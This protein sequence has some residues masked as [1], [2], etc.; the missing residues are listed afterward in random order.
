MKKIVLPLNLN[1]VGINVLTAE[2]FQTPKLDEKTTFIVDKDYSLEGASIEIPI[3]CSLHFNG[4]CF[5]NGKIIGNNTHLTSNTNSIFRSGLE[6][7]GSFD[8]AV[9]VSNWFDAQSDTLM[10]KN[11]ITFASNVHN[12]IIGDAANKSYATVMVTCDTGTYTIDDS[13]ILPIG[14]SFDGNGSL[15]K[16]AMA[17]NGVF[18][19]CT[20][21]ISKVNK[22]QLVSTPNNILD[23]FG[24]IGFLNGVTINN[25]TYYS[26]LIYVGDSRLIHDIKVRNPHKVIEWN[27]SYI[28]RKRCYN[29]MCI[30]TNSS[31]V[32]DTSTVE[33]IK[34]TSH[35]I[36]PNVGDAVEIRGISDGIRLFVGSGAQATIDSCINCDIT[37]HN[38]RDVTISH[39]HNETGLIRLIKSSVRVTDSYF[40][41]QPNGNFVLNGENG[42]FSELLLKNIQV[43]KLCD[44]PN[45]HAYSLCGTN[46]NS[47]VVAENVYGILGNGQDAH[48]GPAIM[49]MQGGS[50]INPNRFIL[51]GNEVM[52]DEISLSPLSNTM[53]MPNI[54]ETSTAASASYKIRVLLVV[55]AK[56]NI[57]INHNNI[58]PRT[59]TTN[60]KC[61][62]TFYN[63]SNNS[64]ELLSGLITRV[65]FG[66]ANSGYSFYFDYGMVYKRFDQFSLDYRITSANDSFLFNG[67]KAKAI[68]YGN[69]VVCKHYK[70]KGK[71]AEVWLTSN[72]LPSTTTFIELDEL[73]LNNGYHYMLLN[74][75]WT[76]I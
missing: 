76:R 31:F 32:Q 29:V 62:L 67:V 63:T 43:N 11:A 72:T 65:E 2:M 39:L 21:V 30:S 15:F 8:T 70:R 47:K 50:F 51:S 58:D 60:K 61:L 66:R 38:T 35:L 53:Q 16:T 42:K 33:T 46:N 4:G 40:Y 22:N 25:N 74:G 69:Y 71:N 18:L 12:S 41:A 14:V 73:Y 56:R 37:I 3:N 68:D 13:L 28:D 55:D 6:I 9:V 10:F 34:N 44:L 19:F 59:I 24:N 17:T 52:E 49:L 36:V 64:V 5:Y 54:Q 23:S 57:Y 75:Q 27:P 45:Y 1:S 48:D 20:N 26:N 7:A